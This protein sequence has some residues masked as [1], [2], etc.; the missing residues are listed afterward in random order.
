MPILCVCKYDCK[1]MH[2]IAYTCHGAPLEVRG[3][4]WESVLDLAPCLRQA[5]LAA[6]IYPPGALLRSFQGI[7][8]SLP[9]PSL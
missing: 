1:Y 3:N 8:L 5:S 9:T 4:L 2:A 7:L 6:V